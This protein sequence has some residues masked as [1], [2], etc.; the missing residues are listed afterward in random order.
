MFLFDAG[1]T[2]PSVT[3][4]KNDWSGT[5]FLFEWYANRSVNHEP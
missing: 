3:T 4:N 5:G 2:L 1:A